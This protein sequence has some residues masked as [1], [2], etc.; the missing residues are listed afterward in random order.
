MLLKISFNGADSSL[1]HNLI[2]FTEISSGPWA[3][4][5]FRPIFKMDSVV[6][7]H[8]PSLAAVKK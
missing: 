7:S 8:E 6:I 1:A 5:A 4:L 2:M 3:L